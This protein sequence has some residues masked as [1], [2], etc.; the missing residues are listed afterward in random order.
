MFISYSW[1]KRHVDLTGV[2]PHDLA[3][4][5]T[6]Q[7]AEVEG[8]EP[9]AP[10]LAEVVVG[11]VL[12]RDAHP[13]AD[14]LGITQVNVGADEPLQI[15]CGAP[16]VGP[17]QLVAVAVVGTKLPTADG[18]T[19]KIKKS[20]IRGVES[21]GM[22]CSERELGLGDEHD[23]IWVLPFAPEDNQEM[24][25]KPVAEALGATEG[26][27]DWIIEIDNKSLTHRPD[28]WG[29][30]GIA[31]EV[32]AILGRDLKP[33]VTELPAHGSAD[34]VPVKVE[35]KGCSRYLGIAIDGLQNGKSPEW[36]R[37]LLLATGQRPIDLLVDISNF[38]ML[39]LA[40]PNHLFDRSELS[41]DGILVRDAKDGEAMTTLDGEERT[42][43]TADMLITSG[44][45]AVAL[46]G[47]M[48]GE[49]SKVKEGTT[50]MLLE[51][52]TFAPTQIR[53]T[54][55]RLALRTDSSAR[56]EKHLDPT[57][58]MK[59]AAH[60][61]SLLAELQPGI[62][63]PSAPSEDGDWS[64]PACEVAVRPDRVRAVLG[65]TAELLPNQ[66][67]EE[68]LTRLGFGVKDA[69]RATWTV[70]VPSARST[71]D[72][73]LEEDLIEEV[74]R[75]YR[76]D[77]IPEQRVM[78]EIAPVA[79][80][81]RRSLVR[82]IQDRLSGASAFD[83]VMTHSFVDVDLCERLGVAGE[84]TVRAIN[85]VAEGY[86]RIRRSVVPNLLGL[87][88]SNLKQQ[89]STYLY[90]V[91]KGYLPE[92]AHGEFEEPLEVHEA[93]LV[94]ARAGNASTE[95]AH[96]VCSCLFELKGV[97][98]DL[99]YATESARPGR[100]GLPGLVWASPDEDMVLAAYA[101]P[102]RCMVARAADAKGKA[103]G[104][105]LAFVSA[106]EP[107]VGAALGL[108]G[109][110]A[111]EVAFAT[112]SIDDLIAAEQK[113]ILHRPIPRFPGVKVD[114]AF[115]LGEAT[116][117]AEAEQIIHQSGKGLVADI[118]LFDLY[119]GE[120]VGAGQKSMA[121]HV[122]LQSDTK[123]LGDKDLHKFLKRVEN[124]ATRIGG[125]LRKD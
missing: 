67:M 114:V 52:A 87:V 33:I 103:T 15:V 88:A 77:N 111:A 44:G 109:D 9:F 78:A 50:Q 26:Q 120:K 24:I 8:V 108:T 21:I 116:T 6:L 110:S 42:L 55:Q 79:R 125:E 76:Y 28:L 11:H 94:I 32:A 45:Q 51:L 40:Q 85:P 69:D 81:A 39:D 93:A 98:E 90:E 95:V 60:L 102:G 16:N 46:A 115:A 112:V 56:F 19:F 57:L 105:V 100:G 59:A 113:P 68:M 117:A 118:E 20:K 7:T 37:H 61:V 31:G 70:Q 66:R 82:S 99:L 3:R 104:P 71:K 25:G 14:K 41:A 72:V 49:A 36:M 18:T 47:I 91:G 43:T 1:L 17:G 22:I 48:G 123:T 84:P 96:F 13:D 124:G 89:P 27:Y 54:S 83:E 23:G 107:G 74:G 80:D 2:S 10:A 121:W 53:L 62:S 4:D 119:Q 64:D 92:R 101:H 63:L 97:V 86:E 65:L 12:S 38:V 122:L 106:I 5:L 58:P 75:S 73:G 29:H 34:T 30:R 35:S